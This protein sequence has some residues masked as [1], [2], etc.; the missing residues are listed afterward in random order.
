MFASNSNVKV[1]GTIV[2]FGKHWRYQELYRESE[3][4]TYLMDDKA[5]LNFK[6]FAKGGG[7]LLDTTVTVSINNSY[8]T[9]AAS[10]LRERFSR[11]GGFYFLEL[12][13]NESDE[14]LG[15]IKMRLREINSDMWE[16]EQGKPHRIAFRPST[17]TDRPKCIGDY[18]G[19]ALF[20]HNVHIWPGHEYH[21]EYAAMRTTFGYHMA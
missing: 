2:T 14:Y 10:R 18:K 16:G 6:S 13:S 3:N 12:G 17:C 8:E 21:S 11:A 5:V 19:N 1:V 7:V 15:V 4:F 9:E 20:I